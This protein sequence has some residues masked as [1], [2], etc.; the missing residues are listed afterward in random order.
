MV[1]E[2]LNLESAGSKYVVDWV[3]GWDEAIFRL[4]DDIATSG[5]GVLLGGDGSELFR[6]TEVLRLLGK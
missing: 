4:D 2:A 5:G 6:K 1:G 3:G